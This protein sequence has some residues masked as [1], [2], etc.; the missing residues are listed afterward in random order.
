MK[1]MDTVRRSGRSLKSAK[2]RTILTALA[3]AV[4]GFT[5][6]LT[7]AASNGAKEYANNLIASNFDKS[8]LIVA[9]DPTLFENGNG[10][11]SKPQEYDP[12]LGTI[13]SGGALGGGQQVKRLTV[14]DINH[15]KAD[16]DIE[17]VREGYQLTFQYVTREGQKKYTG[18]GQAY[19]PAQKPELAAGKVPDT[20]DIKDTEVLLPDAYLSDLGF[21]DAKDAVGKT[22]VITVQQPFSQATLQTLAQQA[23]AGGTAAAAQSAQEGTF[24]N[25]S[26]TYTVVAVTKKSP[27][28]LDF[29]LPPMLVSNTEAKRI[30]DY[31]T[32]GTPNYQKYVIVYAKVKGG[33]NATTLKAEQDKL[34]A[35][36]YG[37]QSVEDTQKTLTQIV[38]I[39]QGIVS[40]FGAIAIIASVFGVINTQYISVLER[41][42]E[43][44]LM[45]AL[46]MRRRDVLRLFALEATWI[47]FLGGILGAI[48]AVVLGILLNPWITKKLS[49]SPGQTLLHFQ[50]IQIV[51]LI[52]VLMII[53]TFAGLLPARKAAKLDPIEALRTE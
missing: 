16:P 12:T 44:G 14:E 17:Q 46:G 1:I 37:V 41:T 2:A 8:E 22:V 47:G 7:F 3:I 48:A 51:A 5:L 27:T 42:R 9:K 24:N 11:A 31:T 13:G 36:G 45:K 18:N 20:G 33:D 10:A 6:T 30:N 29:G 23:A 38:S 32:I 49:L 39:L 34:K 35:E 19:N 43:I 21:T 25:E 50:P 26:T 4:G 52:I 28:S 40:V 53:M 15:L